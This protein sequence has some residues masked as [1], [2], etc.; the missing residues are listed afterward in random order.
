MRKAVALLLGIAVLG[1]IALAAVRLAP[2]ARLVWR[3]HELGSPSTSVAE[4]AWAK[5]REAAPDDLRR[6]RAWLFPAL[7]AYLRQAP[8]L[9]RDTHT[10]DEFG[11]LLIGIGRHHEELLLD[12]RRYESL[13]PAAYWA[14]ACVCPARIPR[15]RCEITLE[16]GSL[17][18]EASEWDLELGRHPQGGLREGLRFGGAF[19]EVKFANFVDLGD[20]PLEAVDPAYAVSLVG[21][22]GGIPA[23]PLRIPATIGHT[24][25]LRQETR[26][27]KTIAFRV[28]ALDPG[29]SV[30]LVWRVL[31]SEPPPRPD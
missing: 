26:G 19:L 15:E 4:R 7:D 13:E 25:V 18:P 21:P 24:F 16:A 1:V 29:K 30:H 11:N 23:S 6:E 9:V 20:V 10:L 31:H 14:L 17:S 8:A 22:D 27:D 5:V 28:T 12:A 3:I 2:R